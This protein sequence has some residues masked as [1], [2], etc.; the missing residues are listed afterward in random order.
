V[1][2]NQNLDCHVD[3]MQTFDQHRY[4]GDESDSEVALDL[5]GR[6][7]V[8]QI[9]NSDGVYWL[10]DNTYSSYVV[11]PVPGRAG[12][13]ALRKFLGEK[14]PHS[15]IA[16]EYGRVATLPEI[17]DDHLPTLQAQLWLNG[18]SGSAKTR[19]QPDS[20]ARG[21]GPAVQQAPHPTPSSAVRALRPQEGLLIACHVKFVA[22][23]L[24]CELK[25]L[26]RWKILNF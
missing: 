5:R 24:K 23:L 16:D 12:A 10:Q 18:S 3:G 1:G 14:L 17:S 2:V 15:L 9:E 21:C 4:D 8:Q 7:H 25:S 13:D 19:S 20:Q 22:E 6:K 11:F 26:H